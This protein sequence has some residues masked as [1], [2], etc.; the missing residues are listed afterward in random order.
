MSHASAD[1]LTGVSEISESGDPGP[2]GPPEPTERHA[3]TVETE[4]PR[5]DAQPAGPRTILTLSTTGLLVA[6]IHVVVSM[7]PSL[8]PRTGLMQGVVSGAC[9]LAGYAVGVLLSLAWRRLRRLLDLRISVGRTQGTVLRIAVP[10][11]GLGLFA[12]AT[13][14]N[15]RSQAVTAAA[16]HLEPLKPVDW[17]VAGGVALAVFGLGLGLA[18]LLRRLTRRAGGRAKRYLPSAIATFAAAVVVTLVAATFTDLVIVNAAGA[19]VSRAA[20]A[21]DRGEP[22]GRSAPTAPELSGSPGSA[23]RYASLGFQGRKFVTGTPP[24]EAITAA[25]GQ[26][27]RQ[28]IRVYA[29]FA[30]HDGLA[31]TA[32]AVVAEL[33][34]TEA[35][36]RKVLNVVTTTGTGWVNDWSL[37][38]IEYLTGGDCA[39]ASMQ[40]SLLPS[41][42]AFLADRQTARDAG[43]LLFE[44]VYAAWSA[45]PAGSRPR[46]VVSGESLGAFGGTAAF[47][48]VDALLT[49]AQGGVWIGGPRFTPLIRRL[50]AD[51]TQSS[52]EIAPVID[53]GRNIRFASNGR[54]LTEDIYGRSFAAWGDSRFVFLQHASDPIV[55]WEPRLLWSEPDWLREQRG[56]GVNPD[57][58]W[59]PYVTFF[60]LASDM[61]L[62]LSPP[63]GY[64]H[65]YGPELVGSWAEVLDTDSTDLTALTAAIERTIPP[66]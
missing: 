3:P 1:T 33:R 17:A 57:I 19:L 22:A 5:T 9:A 60:Q 61:A 7:S 37:Q 65:R 58:R 8:L 44:K 56:P 38:S 36:E 18:R 46:L 28:P 21:T 29:S 25:T 53:S 47:A 6:A 14:A 30:D 31:A 59:F 62:G 16:V 40:Y 54:G 27:A 55:W 48:D 32:D 45:L 13:T 63:A 34:R 2:A 52:P 41:P 15:V 66:E 23:E 42:A 12:W 64:G 11:V 35:F 26:P 50:M 39:S 43:R 49:K 4:H 24:V 51:R 10:L 20:A